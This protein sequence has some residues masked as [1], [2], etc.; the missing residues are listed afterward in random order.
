MS[1]ILGK[2]MANYALEFLSVSQYKVSRTNRSLLWAQSIGAYIHTTTKSF[3]GESDAHHF[4]FASVRGGIEMGP[5]SAN[6]CEALS[7]EPKIESSRLIS[8]I[9]RMQHSNTLAHDVTVCL[10]HEH[11]R[12]ICCKYKIIYCN[13]VMEIR[14]IALGNSLLC[15]LTV[16]A[17][18]ATAV[19]ILSLANKQY[20][21]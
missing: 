21:I 11:N 20:P 19:H 8:P 1:A 18:A 13:L 2:V 14:R 9:I 17:A 7:C 12:K 16:A 6:N 5:W 4:M 10:C 3:D 15:A